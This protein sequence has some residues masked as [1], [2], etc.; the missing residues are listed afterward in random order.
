MARESAEGG[1][2]G[3]MSSFSFP[4]PQKERA[5]DARAAVREAAVVRR[6]KSSE[7]RSNLYFDKP[8]LRQ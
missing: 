6:F 3:T 4:F 2:F 1:I 5:A 8:V 7:N